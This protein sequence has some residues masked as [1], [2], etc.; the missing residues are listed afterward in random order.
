MVKLDIYNFAMMKL[1]GGRVFNSAMTLGATLESKL[2]TWS[3]L[4]ARV[5]LDFEPARIEAVELVNMLVARNMRIALSVPQHREFLRSGYFSEP[6]L[7]EA[8]ARLMHLDSA[9]ETRDA[10]HWARFLAHEMERSI[11][12][13]GQSGEL[14]IRLLL[15]CAH[16]IAV[17]KKR[18]AAPPEKRQRC[19][20]DDHSADPEWDSVPTAN[21]EWDIPV[22]VP[23]FFEAL[24][25]PEF[26]H[27]VLDA[28]PTNVVDGKSLQDKFKNARMRFTH[29]VRASDS[30][31]VKDKAMWPALARGFAWQCCDNQPEIDIMV[32]ILLDDSPLHRSNVSALFI[33]VKNTVEP[34]RPHI[35]VPSPHIKFFS[36]EHS[37]QTPRPYITMTV[38]L[39]TP[40]GSADKNPDVGEFES[41]SLHSEMAIHPRYAFTIHGCSSENYGVIASGQSD[42]W[43]ALVRQGGLLEQHPRQH[44]DVLT[45]VERLGA[46]CSMETLKWATQESDNADVSGPAPPPSTLSESSTPSAASVDLSEDERMDEDS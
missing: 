20:T 9:K 12:N 5:L 33:Q 42:P 25:P 30:N 11:F 24:F 38:N 39:G 45:A 3:A 22:T 10:N 35:E 27:Q 32:P 37:S 31:V 28:L 21:P 43:T 26:G 41:K 14:V 6:I 17:S 4:G 36:D 44:P 29:F 8:A 46:S 40:P 2:A 1:A 13:K 15:I 7:A 18:A 23:E 19:S 34:Q 16:D